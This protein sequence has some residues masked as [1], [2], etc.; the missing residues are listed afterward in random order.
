M[1]VELQLYFDN[2]P[3]FDSEDKIRTWISENT[4]DYQIYATQM[5]N[6]E[7]TSVHMSMYFK[8]ES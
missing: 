8:P 1:A 2:T 5:G 3:E 4:D 6:S 7:G